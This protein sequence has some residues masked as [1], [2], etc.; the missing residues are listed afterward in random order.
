VDVDRAPESNPESQSGD[1]GDDFFD[2][3]EKALRE[4]ERDVLVR[5]RSETEDRLRR[6][7]EARERLLLLLDVS[8]SINS[9]LSTQ[10]VLERV[11]D[12]VLTIS[13]AQRGFLVLLDS[14]SQLRMEISRNLDGS[15][16]SPDETFRISQSILRQAIDTGRTLIVSDALSNPA[17]TGFQSV[18]DLS[19]R[20]VV[21]L[22]LRI[23]QKVLGA[24]YVDSQNVSDILTG[25]GPSL[26]EAFASQAAVAI[27][28]ARSHDSL[29]AFQSRL[30]AEN[31]N[32]KRALRT[33]FSFDSIFGR[34]PAMRRVIEVLDKV[35]ETSVT[36]LIQG[37]TGTGKEVAARALHNSGP[38]RA[39]PFV[40][41]NCGAL[42]EALLESELFGYRRGAFTGATED[43]PG[44]FESAHGGTI[45]LDEIGEMPMPLQVKL[46]RVLQEGE[47]RRI[48]DSQ[49]RKIDVRLLAATNR[50]LAREVEAQRF[51]QDLYYRLNVVA[52]HLPP[53]RER[54]ED[55]LPLAEHFLLRF[56]ERLGRP[57]LHLTADAKTC[58]LAHPWPGNVRELENAVERAC[59]LT[60]GDGITPEHLVPATALLG[61]ETAGG[62]LRDRLLH[63]E[64]ALIEAALR[65][66]GGNVSRAALALGVS[67]QHLHNRIRKLQIAAHA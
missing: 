44:L 58:I 63:A 64:R 27:G 14:A 42:P 9:V 66:S 52:V 26:L 50:D 2:I 49:P 19:L 31:R 20:T 34:S 51:R 39:A 33:E 30:E 10:D 7:T 67:R 1:T 8:R 13:G 47:V 28:N 61:S 36:V 22:P 24:I 60:S 17:F 12:A 65:K 59:A 48:G 11:M 41:I 21:C 18:R 40:A 54:T 32:L 15:G 6:L 5:N 62:T 29:K 46:L 57:G 43:R 53:L 16:T 37:E 3:A 4:T 25:D 55:I 56:T 35:V 45:F 38:R 23:D